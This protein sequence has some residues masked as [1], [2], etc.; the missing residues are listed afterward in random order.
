MKSDY[1]E[2]IRLS[3]SEARYRGTPCFEAVDS[4]ASTRVQRRGG[5][6]AEKPTVLSCIQPTSDPHI[7]NYFGAIANWVRLQ[8]SGEYNCIYGVVDLHAM[9]MPYEP[10]DLRKN[11]LNMVIDLLTC[12]IDPEKS[13]V[14][15]QS[16]VPEHTELSWLLGCVSSYGE[17]SRMTQFK[18][19]SDQLVM[20]NRTKFISVGLFTY[21]VLQAAD[22]LAYRADYVPVGRDQKQHLEFARDAARKFNARFGDFFPEPQ[23][24][25]TETPKIMSPA[26]PE[27]KMSKS[28]GDKH[29][30]GLFD[31]PEVVRKKIRSAVTDVGP[32]EEM[33]PGVA[34]LF[35]ILNACG[36][37]EAAAE[38]KKD[39][40]SKTLR[41]AHLKDTVTSALLRLIEPLRDR[42]GKIEAELRD[43]DAIID[44]SQKARDLARD[45][46]AAARE[47]A[48]LPSRKNG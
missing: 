28:L 48:G 34:N 27:K 33:N 1:A 31:D 20:E 6:M 44:M 25:F 37:Q 15:V 43:F 47:R 23:P 40:D 19:K 11:T 3:E 9:T 42:R 36:E 5:A 8:E 29:Y 21:P 26:D 2:R 41:Y 18:E 35:E 14:F 16:L 12:G 7:G 39:Y 45:T 24:L 13:I 10:D 30:I 46:L 32:T 4:D 17:L 22:I 38:L